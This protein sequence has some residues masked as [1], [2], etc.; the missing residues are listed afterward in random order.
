M[1]DHVQWADESLIGNVLVKKLNKKGPRG[2]IVK[3]GYRY[4]LIKNKK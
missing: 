4:R 3:Y 2:R 1:T